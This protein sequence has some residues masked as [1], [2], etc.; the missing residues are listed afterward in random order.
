[1][2]VRS[3]I[4]LLT[5]SIFMGAV[6]IYSEDN[7]K[8]SDY[9]NKYLKSDQKTITLDEL[10]SKIEELENRM[11]KLEEKHRLRIIPLHLKR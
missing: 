7:M 8:T 4:C 2:S 10:K 6:S 11:E 5:L 1:M 9:L 3:M